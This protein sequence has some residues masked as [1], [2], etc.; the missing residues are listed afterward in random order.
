[1]RLN[2]LKSKD[3]DPL[4]EEGCS[5]YLEGVAGRALNHKLSRI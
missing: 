5:V 1:M 2:H 4:G 3:K